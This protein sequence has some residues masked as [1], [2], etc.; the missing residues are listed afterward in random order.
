MT[1]DKYNFKILDI[2]HHENTLVT[3]TNEIHRDVCNH[4]SNMMTVVHD[5]QNQESLHFSYVAAMIP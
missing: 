3:I 2:F 4:P 5:F 1:F